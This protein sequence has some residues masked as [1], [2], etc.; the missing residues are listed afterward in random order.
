MVMF[1]G[2][3]ESRLEK[4]KWVEVKFARMRTIYF[5]ASIFLAASILFAQNRKDEFDWN[6]Y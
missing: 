5:M 6:I 2:Q 4:Y 1:F 3:K